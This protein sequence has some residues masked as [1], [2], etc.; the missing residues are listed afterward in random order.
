MVAHA[1]DLI[2]RAATDD[3]LLQE[4]APR[5]LARELPDDGAAE[6]AY[7]RE[8]LADLPE[9]AVERSFSGDEA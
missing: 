5:A 3:A 4:L 8:L 6:L 1:L 7:L 9:E 2:E